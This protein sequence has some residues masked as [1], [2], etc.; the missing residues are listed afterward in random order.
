MPLSNAER[1]QRY[2]EKLKADPER[3]SEHKK[4][5]RKRYHDN[6]VYGT[7]KLINEK[8]ERSQ[9]TQRQKLKDVAKQLT[10]PA[11]NDRDESSGP[12]IA[13]FPCSCQ[14]NR[15]REK[16][17]VYRDNRILEKKLENA[18]R[19]IER[20]EKRLKRSMKNADSPRSKTGRH[21]EHNK[22]R[23]TLPF[24]YAILQQL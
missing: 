7:V 3:Y 15:N 9:R 13:I 11:S 1:L 17:K 8:S 10:P 19:T 23:K 12:T 4:K 6:K 5:E 21:F 20:L 18:N 24:H 22:V 16:A 2:R 14:K